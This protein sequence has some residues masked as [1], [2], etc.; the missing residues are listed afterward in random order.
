MD[1]YNKPELTELLKNLNCKTNSEGFWFNNRG[2]LIDHTIITVSV[3]Y[4]A[5]ED[6]IILPIFPENEV[7][8]NE[9]S[10][11]GETTFHRI[12]FHRIPGIKTKE[13]QI[14]EDFPT[15]ATTITIVPI[16]ENNPQKISVNA[17][18]WLIILNEA[19]EIIGI[20]TLDDLYCN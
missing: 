9:K 8:I 18:R 5:P 10:S 2:R 16:I 3:E 19:N 12:K 4:K 13:L 11:N 1:Y 6:Q 17:K 14:P 7:I 20:K 15:K